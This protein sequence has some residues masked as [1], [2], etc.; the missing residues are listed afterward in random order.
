MNSQLRWK[1]IFILVVILVC[2]Y[3]LIGVPDFPTS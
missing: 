3:G 1:F 2:V